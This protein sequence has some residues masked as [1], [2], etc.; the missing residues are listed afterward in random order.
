MF[1]LVFAISFWT[2]ALVTTSFWFSTP[3]IL[4]HLYFTYNRSA[5]KTRRDDALKSL[6]VSSTNR[7]LVGFF[8]PYCNAGG[9]GERVLWAAVAA[10]QR[11]EPEVISVVYSGDVDTSKEEIIEKVKTRFGITLDPSKI[12][13]VFLRLRGLL[14]AATW[15]Y[16]TLLGQSIGSM[17]LVWEAMTKLIPDLYIDTMGYAFT[18]HVVNW[19]AHVPVGTYVHYPTISTDMLGGVK[20][21]KRWHTSL[22]TISS[23]YI[24]SSARL[25]YYRLFMYYYSLSLR[26]ASFL[27]VNSSWTKDHVD[28]ILQHTDP[29]IDFIHLCNPVLLALYFLTTY[30][31]NPITSSQVI[32]PPCDTREMVSFPLKER[33]RVIV[34][35]AQ[36][37]PGKDHATQLYAL[38]ELIKAHPEYGKTGTTGKT[39]VK[40]VLIGG[41]RNEEDAS[42]VSELKML[43]KELGLEDRVEF[44][45]NASYSDMLEWLRKA[46]IGMNTMVEEHF[47]INI[48]EYMAA[49]VIP[50]VHASGGPLKDIVV[51][52]D[53]KPTGYHAQTPGEF[54]EALHTALSLDAEEDLAI[55]ERARA[56]AV[57]KFSQEEFE[58]GWDC[59]GWKKLIRN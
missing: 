25:V 11:N 41:C 1:G 18:F 49:G 19:V 5:N 29:F 59:S 43:A 21:H 56:W 50:V 57:M 24:L 52:Y 13:F 48:V 28:S 39:A 36:F 47:G 3:W 37:R 9:G 45:V 27:I 32:Y 15:P 8:H 53:G 6:G 2:L 46:S 34:S 12:I 51:P 10:L 54:A 38:H 4:L 7:R 35:V 55:R 16:F 40:L 22:D 42:R 17:Y 33:E 23:S 14:D 31:K 26:S 44:F 58:K 30:N 20:N